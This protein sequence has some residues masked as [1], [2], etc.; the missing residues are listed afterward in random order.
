MTYILIGIII[1]LLVV[2]SIIGGDLALKKSQVKGLKT[3][4]DIYRTE[5][6]NLRKE[7]RRAQ[8]K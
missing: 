3:V 8:W 7:L 2:I 6:D 4:I 5:V 1:S